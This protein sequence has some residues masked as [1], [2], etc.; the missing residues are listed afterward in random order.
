MDLELI[1]IFVK[2][3]QNKS[4]SKA[5]DLLKLPK[6]TVSKSISRLE[7]EIETKLLLR[8]TR[9]LTLTPAGR[10][11]Y[12]SSLGPIQTLEEAQKSLYG[13]DSKLTGLVR[14]TVPEDLGNHI[15]APA[16]GKLLALHPSLSF[17]LHYTDDVVDLIKDGFDLAIRLGRVN[18]SSF[19]IKRA[20]VV[21]LIMV[22]TP[23]YLKNQ[24][25]ILH[26][27]DLKFHHCLTYSDQSLN[28]KWTLRSHK[29]IIQAP[30]NTKM[31]CNQMSGLLKM[32]LASAGVALVP[33]FLC[34]S[35]IETGK[36]VHILPDWIGPTFEVSLIS[37]LASTS[38]ARLK[39]TIDQIYSSL[40]K[41]LGD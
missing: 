3:A 28:S 25:K 18:E 20:G 38:S 39:V 19:K 1:R 33:K 36:L 40:Q 21:K 23:K 16:T 4:F 26:P 22:A 27:D 34:K 41:A 7:K 13:L 17:E 12:D 24:K 14:I 30:I 9:S 29:K 6:S 10:L 35:D 37:P 11:F 2:V 8:T 15:I 31:S 5:A 32:A